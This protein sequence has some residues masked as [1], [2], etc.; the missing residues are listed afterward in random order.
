MQT[1]TELVEKSF[2]G[3][4]DIEGHCLLI[5]SLVASM[6]AK[7]VLETGVRAGHSTRAILSAL[8]KAGGNLISVDL[9]IP[10]DIDEFIITDRWEF[11]QG[12]AIWALNNAIT[13][14][15]DLIILDDWH[16][17]KHVAKELEICK[18]LV[19][20][21][22]LILVHDAMWGNT[23]PKYNNSNLP[24]GDEFAFGGPAGAIQA[25]DTNEWEYCTVPAHNGLTMLRYKG[26]VK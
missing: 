1:I 21:N 2:R 4:G 9:E 16:D 18:K 14:R 19:K 8:E 26:V 23:Q 25:L 11:V 7:D 22:H 5:A 12:D 6:K 17:G 10:K 13:G 20:P 3:N 15:F 24:A